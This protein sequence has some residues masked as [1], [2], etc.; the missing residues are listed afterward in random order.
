MLFHELMTAKREEILEAC[1]AEFAHPEGLDHLAQYVTNFFDDIVKLLKPDA[2]GADNTPPL[3]L[4]SLPNGSVVGASA[5][6]TRVR[7]AIDRLSHRSRAHVLILGEAGTGRRHCA[8]AL[9]HATYPDGEFFELGEPDQLSEL[10][11]RIAVLQLRM[12]TQSAGG[13]TVY[14]RELMDSPA[15]IQEK[16]SQLVRERGLPLRVV[17]SSS[18]PLLRQTAFRWDLVA[19]FPNELK[20][21]PLVERESDVSE[22]LE[23]FSGLANAKAGLPSMRFAAAALA[24][25]HAH[26]W[27]GNVVE[28]AALVERLSR[29]H[30]A[31]LVEDSDLFELD[32]RPSGIVFN[33]PATG[34]DLAT[35]ERELLTQALA[36][37]ENNQTRA[38]SLLGLTRDQVRYRMAKFEIV[39][40]SVRSG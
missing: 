4:A 22:L 13:L 5:A 27:P 31:D 11:Q 34:I 38:A 40:P 33:L 16:V 6:M 20:L 18:Q 39:A 35:L 15:N 25:L 28:L 8:R 2:P 29:E 14:V 1:R 10:E 36:M 17:V 3:P 19:S 24:R 21:P 9:H 32:D 23:H 26:S 30:A 7:I 37:A 12:S